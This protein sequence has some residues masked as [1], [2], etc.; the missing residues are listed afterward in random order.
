MGCVQSRKRTCGVP[1]IEPTNNLLRYAES[2]YS[3]TGD[4]LGRLEDYLTSNKIYITEKIARLAKNLRLH[5][6]AP[7]SY[8]CCN[9]II[10]I[11]ELDKKAWK[12]VRFQFGEDS[13]KNGQWKHHSVGR[14]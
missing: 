9:L 8:A 12:I 11:R 5:E 14:A 10:A 3:L 6:D 4:E 13:H 2:G 7:D 1:L